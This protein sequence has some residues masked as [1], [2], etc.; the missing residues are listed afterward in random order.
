[1]RGAIVPVEVD[2]NCRDPKEIAQVEELR[3]GRIGASA[4]ILSALISVI[5]LSLRVA[6]K[7]PVAGW[8]FLG[9]NACAQR[10]IPIETRSWILVNAPRREKGPEKR[11]WSPD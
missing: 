5:V 7:K 6:L 2:M 9:I 4:P 1:V 3:D 8:I 10:S 11:R